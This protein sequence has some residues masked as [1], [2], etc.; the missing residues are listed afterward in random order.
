MRASA[1]TTLKQAELVGTI[2]AKPQTIAELSA[3][4]S[5]NVANMRRRV[6]RL[7]SLNL[8]RPAGYRGHGV[9]W[10]PVAKQEK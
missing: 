7:H 8:V 3:V 10:A 4:F 2:T 9:L 5:R 6:Y 1:Y